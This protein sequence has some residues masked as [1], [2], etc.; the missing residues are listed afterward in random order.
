[1]SLRPENKLDIDET[2]FFSE[3]GWFATLAVVVASFAPMIA[4]IFG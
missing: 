1:M 2:R 3:L 4:D